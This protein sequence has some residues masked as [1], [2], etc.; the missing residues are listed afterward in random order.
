MQYLY[1]ATAADMAGAN[2]TIIQSIGSITDSFLYSLIEGINQEDFGYHSI[3]SVAQRIQECKTRYFSKG[4][5]FVDSAGYSILSG[6][7]APDKIHAVINCWEYYANQEKDNYG[8][9]FS[10][11]IPSSMQYP[12]LN[13]K[14][15]I[16][17]HNKKSLER[18]RTLI[19]AH[20]CIREKVYFVWHFKMM[21]Q[22][23]IWN[24]LYQ[25]LEL[26]R[27]ISH[28]AIGG[29]VGLHKET[30]IRFSPFTPMSYRCL[31]DYLDAGSFDR[32]FGLHLLGM[33]IVYDRFQIAFL[34][35]LFSCYLQSPGKVVMSY[36]SINPKHSAMMNAQKPFFHFAEEN[37][38]C[39]TGIT[40]IPKQI[41]EGIYTDVDYVHEEIGRYMEFEKKLQNAATF[42]PLRVYSNLCLDRF[43]EWIIDHYELVEMMEST[44]ITTLMGNFSTITKDMAKKW[45]QVFTR[46]VC[47]AMQNNMRI[48]HKYHRWF[49]TKR[50]H[51][52][53]DEDMRSF[54][55]MINYPHRLQ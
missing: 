26:S 27:F 22:Y 21:E 28:R 15:L 43:F 53:L 34:E 52:T 17:T 36:D 37:I 46:Q 40:D 30:K 33:Y 41:I 6:L 25:E 9:L 16:Y 18:L 42:T 39:F 23:E 38:S 24:R 31:L 48:T 14:A 7:V 3:T 29:M 47:T 19:E 10:L 45:P 50:D 51:E 11:D 55:K 35:K 4:S 2:N 20:P 12:E 5:L 49:I 44:S 8:F 1:V 54:I 13:K 32:E